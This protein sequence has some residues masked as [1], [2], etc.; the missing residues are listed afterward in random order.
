[1]VSLRYDL[2]H[3]PKALLEIVQ[4]YM[5]MLVHVK[6]LFDKAASEEDTMFI[7]DHIKTLIYLVGNKDEYDG[8]DYVSND[9]EMTHGKNALEAFL[10]SKKVLEDFVTKTKALW[11][12]DKKY[13]EFGYNLDDNTREELDVII[14]WLKETL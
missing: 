10:N 5:D 8:F 6:A 3:S 12:N 11:Q 9:T 2:K 13:T 7:L 1:M 4:E 14:L